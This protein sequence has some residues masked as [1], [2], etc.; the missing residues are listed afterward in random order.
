MAAFFQ[1]LRDRI[2]GG[3]YIIL[4]RQPDESD[5]QEQ[6]STSN[7]SLNVKILKFL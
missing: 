2:F 6:K 3:A 7:A 1:L 4:Q 5:N